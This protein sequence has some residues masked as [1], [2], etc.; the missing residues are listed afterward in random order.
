MGNTFCV[1]W[2]RLPE[3]LA[4][5]K[6]KPLAPIFEPA[7]FEDHY[8]AAL[9]ELLEKKQKGQPISAAKKATFQ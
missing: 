6:R 3:S 2:C 4:K 7:K 5:T 1:Q 9:Q 8:E